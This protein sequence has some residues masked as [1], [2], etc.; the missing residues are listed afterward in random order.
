MRIAEFLTEQR[1]P[2]EL[3]PHP[4]AFTAQ[5][6][7]K[8]LHV[9]GAQVAKCVLLHGPQGHFLA[10]LP[11]THHVDTQRLSTQLGGSV[12]LAR[13]S[14]I[15]EVFPDCEWGVVPPFGA[16]Y[17]LPTVLEESLDT[18][19]LLVFELHTHVEAVRL[20]CGDFERLERPRR[21]PFA[22]KGGS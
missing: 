1:V 3:L 4:P 8:W 19:S 20:H 11:A 22:V 6:R 16:L 13:D 14:E 15:A 17:G 18:H 10:I 9:P 2:H 12:R 5:K 7:A 21:L